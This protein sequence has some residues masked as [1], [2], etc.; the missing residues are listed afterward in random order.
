MD[1]DVDKINPDTE[2]EVVSP[3]N[4]VASN[5]EVYFDPEPAT[6]PVSGPAA[7][8]FSRSE[9]EAESAR[10]T[11][12][13]LGAPEPKEQALSVSDTKL[14][15]DKTEPA[16]G[17]SPVLAIDSH[18]AKPKM[19]RKKLFIL[20]GAVAAA[21]VLV[22]GSAF[23][24]YHYVY[25]NPARV[26]GD[27]VSNLMESKTMAF[28][29]T[30]TTGASSDKTKLDFS[31]M[32]S[33]SDSSGVFTLK[34]TTGG[35]QV[36]VP[37]D[38]ASSSDTYYFKFSNLKQ[39]EQQLLTPYL[40]SYGVDSSAQSYVDG[41][42][43]KLD[44]TWY[45]ITPSDYKSYSPNAQCIVNQV[46][47]IRT[48]AATQKELADIYVAHP[49]FTITKQLGSRGGSL[50]YQIKPVTD[51]Q[52][53]PFFA[54]FADSKFFKGLQSCDSSIKIDLSQF[55]KP[56]KDTTNP[57]TIQVWVSRWS[58][59]LTKITVDSTTDSSSATS[60]VLNVHP[61]AKVSVVMP[62]GAKTITELKKDITDLYDN[63]FLGANNASPS[64]S[65]LST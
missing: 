3:H 44:N 18:I 50:G 29:G 58:H 51:A 17:Q 16:A 63:L 47:K 48:D 9:D 13:G 43:A 52:A 62:T 40:T 28:D 7:P 22:G 59:Q 12:S 10:E 60:L 35:K 14:N 15:T 26:L 54:A 8:E 1:P 53:K 57:G 39:L 30:L 23:A 21:I 25:Q 42:V 2:A 55:D 6:T 36:T 33:G 46:N 24:Y 38:V 31:G 61:G 45:K 65:L 32:N 5:P 56:S 20:S 19:S 49:L 11:T 34:T 41:L 4:D 64:S 27:A 37:I